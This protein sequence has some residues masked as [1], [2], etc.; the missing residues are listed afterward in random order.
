MTAVQGSLFGRTL[1]HEFGYVADMIKRLGAYSFW[2]RLG[3][4]EGGHSDDNKNGEASINAEK[5][6]EKNY[7]ANIETPDQV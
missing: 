5:E 3:S 4:A 7:N 6:F 1:A 2:N